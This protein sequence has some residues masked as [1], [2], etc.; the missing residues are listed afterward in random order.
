M[1]NVVHVTLGLDYGG[2]EKLLVEFAR[3]ADRS[4]FALHF[5]SLTTAGPIAADLDDAGWP[6][7]ALH[8]PGG[9][10]P[11]LVYTLARRFTSLK[12]H[13]V[14]THDERPNIHAAPAAWLAGARCIHTRHGQAA[15]L[16]ARQRL[17]VRAASEFNE[18]FACLS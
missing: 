2:Q 11:D 16:T 7:T 8:A 4:R 14:H 17:L 13:V 1:I 5:L 9:L 12:A 3:H 18:V 10:R 6:I 15:R